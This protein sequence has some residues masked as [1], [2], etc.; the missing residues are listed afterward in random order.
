MRFEIKK[1]MKTFHPVLVLSDD[2]GAAS[3]EYAILGSLIA[4]VI[5][6]VVASLG[7]QV[8]SMF[9]TLTNAW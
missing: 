5:A 7:T 9:E 6:Y 2:K 1:H 8:R 4:A 3:I